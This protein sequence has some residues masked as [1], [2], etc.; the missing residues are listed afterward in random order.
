MF[1]NICVFQKKMLILSPIVCFFTRCFLEYQNVQIFK[2]KH[3]AYEK[4]FYSRS[5]FNSN[6]H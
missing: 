2:R 3:S 5:R 4:D 1:K 6:C